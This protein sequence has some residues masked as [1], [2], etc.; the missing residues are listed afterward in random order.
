MQ[1]TKQQAHEVQREGVG[2]SIAS[3][4]TKPEVSKLDMCSLVSFCDLFFDV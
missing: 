2:G 1:G 4:I 3:C